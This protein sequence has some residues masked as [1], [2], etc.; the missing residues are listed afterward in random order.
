MRR[1]GGRRGQSEAVAGF[2]EDGQRP[3]AQGCRWAGDAGECQ[4]TGSF[5]ELPEE[6]NPANT[7]F[8]LVKPISETSDLHSCQCTIVCCFEPVGL[9]ICH[10]SSR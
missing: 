6:C 1:K 3:G 5:L 2:E 9:V 4:E 10:H 7:D 8:N